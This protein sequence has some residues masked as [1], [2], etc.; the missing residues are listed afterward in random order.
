[1]LDIASGKAVTGLAGQ[2]DK[3]VSEMRAPLAAHREPAGGPEQTAKCAI[4]FWT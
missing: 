3:R 1:M 2:N 4:Y